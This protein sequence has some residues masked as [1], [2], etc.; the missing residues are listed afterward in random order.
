MSFNDLFN[1]IQEKVFSRC[2]NENIDFDDDDKIIDII[3]EEND[4]Y[5]DTMCIV[6]VENYLYDFDFHQA[7]DIY[8]G[9]YGLASLEGMEKIERVKCLLKCALLDI[10]EVDADERYIDW[11]AEHQEEGER[12]DVCVCVC[13]CEGEGEGEGEG[14]RNETT[15]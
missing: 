9:S 1:E 2:K 11:C 15:N 5:L 7:L 14:E 4:I 3:R 10:L 13:M 8:D 12:E 6:C